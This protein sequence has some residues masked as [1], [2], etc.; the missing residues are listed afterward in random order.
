MLEGAGNALQYLYD[1]RLAHSSEIL[2]MFLILLDSPLLLNPDMQNRK[3]LDQ[4]LFCMLGLPQVL[5]ATL[6]SYIGEH[7]A[8]HFVM[9]V[10]TF[11]RFLS[12]LIQT[13]GHE[14]SITNCVSFLSFLNQINEVKRHVPFHELYNDALNALP[15]A[16]LEQEYWK[17][18]NRQFSFCQYPFLLSA[19][20]K[21]EILQVPRCGRVVF[22]LLSRYW[23]ADR[24]DRLDEGAN[25]IRHHLVGHAGRGRC[26]FSCARHSQRGSCIPGFVSGKDLISCAEHC[27]RRPFSGAVEANGGLEETAQGQ[28]RRG[29][30]HR[31][32]RREEGILSADD[33]GHPGPQLR[34]VRLQR[35]ATHVLVQH[36]R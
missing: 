20:V 13:N 3:Q 30:G 31:C 29:G 27:G 35:A 17:W 16:A 11:E 4:I 21:S 23:C 19:S 9:P 10:R 2:R 12:F 22:E 1:H 24:C 34:H 18:R 8:L 28:V 36:I 6:L 26:S 5:K 7:S 32:R 33:S 14:R 25:G 15:M